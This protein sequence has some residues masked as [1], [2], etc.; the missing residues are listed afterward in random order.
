MILA[1]FTATMRREQ[2]PRRLS[3]A[4]K[5][6]LKLAIK[7]V[8]AVSDFCLSAQYRSNTCETLKYMFKYLRDFHRYRHIFGEYR[9]SKA[10][11]QKA[12]GGSKD[13][14]ASQARQ[15]TISNYFQVTARQKVN[16]VCAD[17]QERHDLMKEMLG[18][19]TCNYP[20]LHLLTHYVQQIVKFGSLPQCSTEITET[21]H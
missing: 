18:Q 1:C 11:D 20:K 16:E 19:A 3:A 13:L 17:R 5:R 4:T 2:D 21:L 6:D 10:D 9:A 12:K 7:A 14:G 15:S 8:R